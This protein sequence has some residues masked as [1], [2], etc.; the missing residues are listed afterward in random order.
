[1]KKYKLFVDELGTSHPSN[2][3]LQPY[4]I[5]MGC[6]IDDTYQDEIKI[7]ADQIK[8]K[9]WGHTNV[10]LHSADMAND[11]NAFMIF[12]GNPTS[13]AN[14]QKD[15]LMFMNQLKVGLTVCVV[16][17]QAISVKGWN[18]KKIVEYTA[19]S[20]MESF[21]AKVKANSPS[22]G[23]MIFEISKGFKDR[24]YLETFNYLISPNFSRSDTDYSFRDVQSLLT[25]INFVTKLNHDIETQ[26][27]DI[28]SYA[29]KCKVLK[30]T[31]KRTFTPG[32]YESEIVKILENK[33]IKTPPSISAAKK[34]YFDK[35][36]SFEIV[37]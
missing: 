5:L 1:M 20:V 34:I 26:I 8:F 27:S 37:T 35:I 25:S 16:D 3:A 14:F 32:S 2:I 22:N 23:K 13:K 7:H 11:S 21:L 19:R 9:Y 30:D 4:Y 6:I 17:K 12:S 29:A 10:V 28:L 18:E 36:R 15:L 33:L 31:G 24:I